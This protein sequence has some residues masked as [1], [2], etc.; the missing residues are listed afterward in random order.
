MYHKVKLVIEKDRS[1]FCL[2]S[3]TKKVSSKSR[4]FFFFFSVF[5]KDT[6]K[7]RKQLKM[8]LFVHVFPFHLNKQMN[9]FWR[10]YVYHIWRKFLKNLHGNFGVFLRFLWGTVWGWVCDTPWLS[11]WMLLASFKWSS[12]FL[13]P[14]SSIDEKDEPE[15][16][17]SQAFFYASNW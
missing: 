9:S 4:F 16:I 1:V 12:S 8:L 2:F 13:S 6:G 3:F 17:S 15:A 11:C 14:N 7:E 5:K 10:I